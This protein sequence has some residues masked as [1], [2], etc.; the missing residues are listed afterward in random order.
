VKPVFQEEHISK[1]KAMIDRVSDGYSVS[2]SYDAVDGIERSLDAIN[3][4]Q[5]NNIFLYGA[6]ALV[7]ILALVLMYTTQKSWPMMF[8]IVWIGAF[9]YYRVHDKGLSAERLYKKSLI[10]PT[11]PVPKIDYLIADIDRRIG[12]KDVLKTYLSLV[13]S[14]AVMLA[15]HL[16]VDSSVSINMFLLIGAVIASYFFW[17]HFYKEDIE[18]LDL[19]KQ[20][21]HDLKSQILLRG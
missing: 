19:V 14:S 16:F 15:H 8:V 7:V 21:L 20:Q 9:M 1:L 13:L 4:E 17:R 18:A 11:T 5:E 6:A 12:R 2:D 3:D 10:T